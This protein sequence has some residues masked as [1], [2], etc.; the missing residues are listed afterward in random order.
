MAEQIK[1]RVQNKGDISDIR[2]LMQHPM[3]TGQRK[4]DMGQTV[5]IHFIHNFTVNLNGKP[6]IEGLLNTS[7]SKNPLFTSRRAAS[8]PVTS[9]P[10]RGST[11]EETTVR[12]K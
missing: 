12:T 9:S 2:I 8:R 4:D 1:I 11:M 3:E 5:P 7:I 6:M 10:L